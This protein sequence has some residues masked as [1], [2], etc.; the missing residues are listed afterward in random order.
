MRAAI[1]GGGALQPGTEDF[2]HAIGFNLLEGYG[3]TETAPVIS[4][5]NSK[6][7]RSNNVGYVFPSFEVKI[8]PEKDGKL[9]SSTPLKPG[10]KGLVL[11]K[12][13]QVMKGYYKRQDLTDAIID[14]EG[15]INTGD[16]GMISWDKELKIVGRAKDTIVLLGGEN[17]EPAVIER[18]LNESPYVERTVVVG[19]DQ[20][21]VAAM[22]V[23]DQTNVINFAEENNIF[24]DSYESLL[25]T[26][27]IQNLFR[28][29]I[30]L[31]DN[32]EKGFRTCERIFKFVLL[33][34]S[35]EVNKEINAKQ[36]LMRHKI[37]QIY[38]K[39]YKKLFK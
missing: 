8:C 20:K 13:R 34:K 1:S 23:P 38:K 31:R 15:W 22:I 32:A 37:V 17:I 33:S 24:Y 27:E 39:E 25:E 35:F 12:G 4:V 21:Y 36:E 28:S 10:K 11:V 6:K 30:D 26:N 19:Q 2:F 7:P 29:E 14:S 9:A 18:A 16:L 3:M 5:R